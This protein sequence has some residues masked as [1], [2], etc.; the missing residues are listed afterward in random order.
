MNLL[1]YCT[2]NSQLQDVSTWSHETKLM[3]EEE[4]VTKTE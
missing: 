4:L 1:G 3:G 2:R